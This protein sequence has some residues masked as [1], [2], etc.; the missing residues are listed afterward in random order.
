MVRDKGLIELFKAAGIVHK[1]IPN[2]CFLIIGPADHAR[3]DAISPDVAQKYEISSFCHFL[4][5]RHDMPEM[6]SLMDVFVLPSHREGFGLVLAEASS[7]GIPVIATDIT[8]CREVVEQ[9]KNGLL[10]SKGD[11]AAL[12]DAII[13]ILSNEEKAKKM[14]EEGRRMAQERYDEKRVF[15]KIV[16]EYCCL[17]GKRGFHFPK[18]ESSS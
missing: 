16:E 2:V 14:G 1:K 5:F 12:A 4:G 15:E 11:I 3:K 10:I 7:M 17:L 8:G 6:Y 18:V 9:R 13:E